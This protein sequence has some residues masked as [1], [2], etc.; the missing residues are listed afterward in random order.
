MRKSGSMILMA[1]LIAGCADPQAN[2]VP[3][4]ATQAGVPSNQ[5]AQSAPADGI[6]YVKDINS[7]KT[8]YFGPVSRGEEVVVDSRRNQVRVGG[9]PVEAKTLMTT[10]AY[11]VYFDAAAKT[12]Q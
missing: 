11:C 1:V 9:K 6:V 5:C 2:P 7:G 12:A 10:G 8:V 3:R 4:T